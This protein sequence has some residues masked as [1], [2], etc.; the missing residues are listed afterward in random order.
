[1]L[2]FTIRQRRACLVE[3]H[4]DQ[5][6]FAGITAVLG[7][8]HFMGVL[9]EMHHHVAFVASHAPLWTRGGIE[10]Q[11]ARLTFNAQ[12]DAKRVEGVL[13]GRVGALITAHP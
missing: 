12:T 2:R 9:E 13:T 11:D 4:Y 8:L 10:D 7:H 6:G 5:G 1:M 3:V